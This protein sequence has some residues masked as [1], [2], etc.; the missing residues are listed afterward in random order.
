MFSQQ[1]IKEFADATKLDELKMKNV[2]GPHQK[3]TIKGNIKIGHYT[4]I[5]GPFNARGTVTIGKYCAFGQYVAIISNNHKTSMLNQQVWLQIRLGAP[6]CSTQKGPIRIG[7]NVWI[8]DQAVVLS[9]VNVGHGAVIA[10]NATVTKDVPPFAIV[11]G[12][13]ARVLKYR[14][15]KTIIDQMLSIQWWDWDEDKLNRN[16]ALF[17][18]DFANLPNSFDLLSKVVD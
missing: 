11:A 8:G 3:W 17:E 18:L 14:F 2:R 7:H 4:S 9:G 5:N 10:A 15:P 12:S 6:P 1:Q 13:P 16:V